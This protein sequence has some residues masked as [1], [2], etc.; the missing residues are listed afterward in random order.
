MNVTATRFSTQARTWIL[1][2]GLSALL[3]VIGGRV[4]VAWAIAVRRHLRRD[5]VRLLLVLGSLAI[6]S[7]HAVEI[8][9]ADDPRLYGIVRDL[10]QR[11]KVPMPRVYVIPLGAA[12]RV[13]DRPQPASTPPWP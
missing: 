7:S 6:R 11:A 13:R 12:E 1:I 8:S 4:S 9:E 2:A 10:A 5:G 3:V